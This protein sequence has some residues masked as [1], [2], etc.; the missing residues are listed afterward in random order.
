MKERLQ[1]Y[2]YLAGIL[3]VTAVAGLAISYSKLYLFHIVFVIT[4]LVTCFKIIRERRWPLLPTRYHFILIALAIW[5]ALSILWSIEPAYSKVYLFYI[6]L[7][8]TFSLWIILWANTFSRIWLAIRVPGVVFAIEIAFSLLEAF[9]GFRLPVSPFSTIS[10]VFGRPDSLHLF[11]TSELQSLF[12]TPTGF[13]WNPNNLGIAMCIVLPF[14]IA[15]S[16]KIIKYA[17]SIAIFVVVVMSGSRIS[18]AACSMI[19]LFYLMVT[20]IRFFVVGIAVY[21]ITLF[22]LVYSADVLS[23]NVYGKKVYEITSL[24][25]ATLNMILPE[26][27]KLARK[28]KEINIDEHSE[29]GVVRRQLMINGLTAFVESKGLGVGGGASI[30]VQEKCLGYV[31]AKIKSMHNFWLEVLVEGGVVGF[32]LLM[33]LY[34]SLLVKLFKFWR[35]TTSSNIR[36][37]TLSFFMALLFYL[38]AAISASTV[39]YFL[40]MWLLLGFSVAL[41]NILTHEKNKTAAAG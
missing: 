41:V 17:G 33:F 27:M 32:G 19:I 12:I 5:Y 38:F 8:V 3:L 1:A 15:H 28:G 18:I 16:N 24:Y 10:S 20:N 4:G 21:A 7:G 35:K 13:R 26:N 11:N 40:P 30:A 36:Y 37:L 14:S 34:V 39:V 2:D 6:A 23:R 22:I 31:G 29:S 25:E 9:T